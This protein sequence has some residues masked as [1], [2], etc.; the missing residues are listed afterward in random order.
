MSQ[1]NSVPFAE[2]NLAFKLDLV[3]GDLKVRCNN[4]AFLVPKKSVENILQIMEEIFSLTEDD[5]EEEK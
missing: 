5:E 1:E 3:T 4:N 2:I